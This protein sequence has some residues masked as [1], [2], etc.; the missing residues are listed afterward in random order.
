M[1]SSAIARLA[2]TIVDGMAGKARV[3]LLARKALL[4]GGRDD[5]SVDDQAAALS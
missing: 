1:S 5:A 3:V 4:L 2:E